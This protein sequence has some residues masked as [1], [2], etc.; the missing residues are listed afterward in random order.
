MKLASITGTSCVLALAGAVLAVE[1]AAVFKVPYFK[2]SE[3]KLVYTEEDARLHLA[4]NLEFS[5]LY[6]LED[7]DDFDKILYGNGERR[8][9]AIDNN[10]D[11]KLVIIINGVET[12]ATFFQDYGMDPLYEVEL[13]DDRKSS[14]FKGFLQ[15]LPDQLYKVKKQLGYNMKKLSNEISVISDSEKKT[16]YLKKLWTKYFHHEDNKV[17][18]LWNNLKDTVTGFHEDAS[19][20][21]N[22]LKI[23]KRHVDYINDE[24]F[25]DE[26]TQLDFLLNDELESQLSNDNIIINLDSLISIFKKT[27][28]TQTYDTCERII[29]KVLAEKLN[30]YNRLWATIVV[31]PLDQ[32]LA[33]LKTKEQF[34]KRE[35]VSKLQKSDDPYLTNAPSGTRCFANQLSCIENTDSCSGHGICSLVG[36]CYKCVCS[37]TKNEGSDQLTYWAGNSCEKVN[38]SAQ[39]HLIFWTVVALI[40]ATTAGVRTL[41]QSGESELPGVL[42]AATVQTKKNN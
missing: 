2:Q 10:Q 35:Y 22:V 39:T 32:S 11:K 5:E 6:S 12:P 31:L 38:F 25:I 29:S 19:G 34:Q 15:E 26:L 16:S 14:I 23:N 40:V 41:Y 33:T 28:H 1:N 37:P 9:P 13:E 17:E 8:R 36:S 18:S 3:D 21:E 30:N 7:S 42:K 27:G 24:S 20:S 4:Y